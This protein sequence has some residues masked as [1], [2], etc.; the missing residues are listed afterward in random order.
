MTASAACTMGLGKGAGPGTVLLFA[1]ATTVPAVVPAAAL[2]VPPVLLPTPPGPTRGDATAATAGVVLLL[3]PWPATAAVAPREGSAGMLI[4]APLLVVNLGAAAIPVLLL[5]MLSLL[6]LSLSEEVLLLPVAVTVAVVPVAAAAGASPV[7]VAGAAAAP[8]AIFGMSCGGERTES[9]ISRSGCAERLSLSHVTRSVLNDTKARS[10]QS[11]TTCSICVYACCLMAMRRRVS[12]SGGIWIPFS[13][14][15]M[16]SRISASAHAIVT[17][18]VT[19]HASDGARASTAAPV[20]VPVIAAADIVRTS[21]P[22]AGGSSIP[23]GDSSRPCVPAVSPLLPLLLAPRAKPPAVT[24]V[25][26]RLPERRRS[27]S[28]GR[29]NARAPSPSAVPVPAAPVPA[30]AAA[31][32]T[33]SERLRSADGELDADAQHM[34]PAV[35]AECTSV[36]VPAAVAA[37]L[38]LLLVL[39]LLATLLPLPTLLLPAMTF[40]S[41]TQC[42]ERLA[43]R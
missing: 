22:C 8:T 16:C 3:S 38:G 14:M 15:R 28:N 35:L 33:D 36:P 42:A 5:L 25:R 10:K 27:G 39:A 2:L 17:A 40:A 31:G 30:A 18:V 9:R 29:S 6:L 11:C 19:R 24:A 13:T 1:G 20:V 7:A 26:V 32:S 41:G 23:A 12:T 34:R 37:R 43:R 4:E 21:R